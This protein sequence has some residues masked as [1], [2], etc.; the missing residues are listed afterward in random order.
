[1]DGVLV[2]NEK[3]FPFHLAH[4]ALEKSST[5]HRQQAS[6]EYHKIVNSPIRESK[7]DVTPKTL[8][9]PGNY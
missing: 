5:Y 6:L 3:H 9:S 8:G 7:D 1:M 4:H 2:D